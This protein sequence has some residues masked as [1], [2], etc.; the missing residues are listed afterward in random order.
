MDTAV[1]AEMGS[2]IG[3]DFSGVRIHTDS[4]AVQMSSALGAQAFTHGKDIYFN[5][6]KYNPGSPTFWRTN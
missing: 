5:Q 6:G 4:K 2:K 3:A 1:S